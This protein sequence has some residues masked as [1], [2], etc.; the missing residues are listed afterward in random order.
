MPSAS[1]PT[2][3]KLTVLASSTSAKPPP[4]STRPSSISPPPPDYDHSAITWYIRARDWGYDIGEMN[5]LIIPLLPPKFRVLA[6]KLI[7]CS[8]SNTGTGCKSSKEPDTSI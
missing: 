1:P 4:P 2:G 6:Y 7:W 3:L 8:G 5:E